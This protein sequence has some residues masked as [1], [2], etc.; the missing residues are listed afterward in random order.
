ME[1]RS[2]GADERSQRRVKPGSVGADE[3]SQRRGSTQR[4][5]LQ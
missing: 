3:R 2:V 4:A 5:G 1:P